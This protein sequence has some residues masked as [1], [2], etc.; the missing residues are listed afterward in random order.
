MNNT[1]ISLFTALMLLTVSTHA[2]TRPGN[3]LRI[4][5]TFTG[6]D[7]RAH[8][9]KS[10]IWP[11]YQ[12]DVLAFN[13]TTPGPTIRVSRG[14]IFSTRLV[15]ART[16]PLTVHWHDVLAPADMDGAGVRPQS[17]FFLNWLCMKTTKTMTIHTVIDRLP[18]IWQHIWNP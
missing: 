14:A 4:P 3:A 13:G 17:L 2:Q 12:T 18:A 16:E 9:T 8:A 11:G 1:S 15:N 5:P 7:L 6:G 10:E